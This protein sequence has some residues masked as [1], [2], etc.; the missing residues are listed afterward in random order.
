MFREKSSFVTGALGLRWLALLMG[1]WVGWAAPS[2]STN[3]ALESPDGGSDQADAADR[4][5]EPGGQCATNEDCADPIGGDLVCHSG[6]CTECSFDVECGDR[7]CKDG[8]CFVCLEDADCPP[9]KPKCG[10]LNDYAVARACWECVQPADCGNGSYCYYG[11]GDDV[12]V[13]GTCRNGD[14]GA[15]P[16][17]WDCF[18]CLHLRSLA[19]PCPECFALREAY[20]GCV[21]DAGCLW[22]DA[23]CCQD[24]FAAYRACLRACLGDSCN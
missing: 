5:E 8:R 10:Q 13:G 16:E 12:Y 4:A 2:C 15:D 3:D 20:R 18:E 14:C 17:A 6:S 24:P 23:Q 1:A 21:G 7:H 11:S 19:G 9:S 22:G